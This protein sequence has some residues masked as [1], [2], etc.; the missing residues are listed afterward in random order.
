MTP[1][2][3]T[4][5][6]RLADTLLSAWP[7]NSYPHDAAALLRELAAEPQR[8]PLSDA[9]IMDTLKKQGTGIHWRLYV[10]TVRAI[11]A[12]HGIGETK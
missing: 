12:A 3:R 6:L 11:E 7:D 5:A 4:A 1:T 8:Q 2:Q 10:E 9:Q